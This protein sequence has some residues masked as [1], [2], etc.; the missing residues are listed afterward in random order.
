M[1]VGGGYFFAQQ[2]IE[3]TQ[4]QIARQ[5]QSVLE[6]AAQ[7]L[8]MHIQE[9]LKDT[10]FVRSLPNLQLL[11][12]N[13]PLGNTDALAGELSAFVN[14]NKGIDQ[15]RW[16]D[17]TGD[18]R[19]RVNTVAGEAYRVPLRALQNKSLNAYFSQTMLLPQGSVYLSELNLNMEY[20]R[21]SLPLKPVLRVATPVFDGVGNRRGVVVINYFANMWIHDLVKAAGAQ[22]DTLMLLNQDGY[23][24]HHPQP[25]YE[26]GFMLAHGRTLKTLQP[27]L[28]RAFTANRQGKIL[29]ADG[30]WVWKDI[31]PL[32]VAQSALP[33]QDIRRERAVGSDAYLWRIA[34][35]TPAQ[36]LRAISQRVWRSQLPV[37]ALLLLAAALVAAWLARSR[38]LIHRLNI[39]LIDKANAAQ[40]AS[41]AKSAFLSNMSHEIR[42]PL[43]AIVGLTR[44]LGRDSLSAYQSAQLAK[45]DTAS[46]HLVSIVSDILDL[47]KAD[48]SKL[49]LEVA[50]FSV[51]TVFD[52]VRA[53]IAQAAHDKGLHIH[54]DLAQAPA[55]LLGDV[56]RV[57]QA[58]LNFAS[59]AVKFTDSG[60]IYL[61]ASVADAQDQRVLVKFEVQDTGAGLEPESLSKLFEEFVQAD[62]SVTREYGGTGLGLV[63]VKRLANIMGGD[64]GATS[65][66]DQGST[67][68]FTAWM[69]LGEPVAQ[70][71][72]QQNHGCEDQLRNTHAG[73]RILLAEDN[74]VNREVALAFLADVDLHVTVADDGEQAIAMA[75]SSHYDLVLMDVQMP[76]CDGLQATQAIRALPGWANIPIV[77]MTAN[78]FAE[79]KQACLEAGMNDFITKPVDPELLYAALSKHLG[80]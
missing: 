11:L 46:K 64:A 14:A 48:A 40:A 35:L 44:T 41:V 5:Q 7:T 62:N 8:S 72:Q 37:V 6:N 1:V 34:S 12:T 26:W 80:S 76:K 50:S 36:E 38:L 27:D 18:E 58:L 9:T 70:T 13:D 28:W 59:N 77:A 56:T 42:T 25:D 65:V 75:R 20:D 51:A 30:L 33:A 79:D 21:V 68:W 57:R 2:R 52:N 22:R 19:V 32:E 66:L 61:R 29:Q 43:N 69:A 63:I 71:C 54:V 15:L 39:E 23:W 55:W 10:T 31:E 17:E 73:A 45:I 67:F 78:A 60:H 49:T 4:D 24:L 16:I 47:A 3:F 74:P 53:F